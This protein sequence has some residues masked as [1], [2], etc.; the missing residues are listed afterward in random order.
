MSIHYGDSLISV[1]RDEA[2]IARAVI[3]SIRNDW[4]TGQSADDPF[5]NEP[6]CGM[7][8]RVTEKYLNRKCKGDNDEEFYARE[9]QVQKDVLRFIEAGINA[10][11]QTYGV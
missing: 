3:Q 10:H 6:V 4:E 9:T 5:M 1:R 8:I 2:E 7:V 11:A